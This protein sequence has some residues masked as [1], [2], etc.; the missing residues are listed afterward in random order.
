MDVRG[1]DTTVLL[2]GNGAA[3]AATARRPAASLSDCERDA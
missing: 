3:R 2:V 1:T